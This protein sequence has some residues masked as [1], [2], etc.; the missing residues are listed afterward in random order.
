MLYKRWKLLAFNH[1]MLQLFNH[2]ELQMR[3][4]NWAI[5][6]ATF[7]QCLIGAKTSE[8][9]GN[10]ASDRQEIAF[11]QLRQIQPVSVGLE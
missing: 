1:A 9:S 5:F 4:V 8:K 2:F 11:G 7:H 6:L 3:Y 10:S